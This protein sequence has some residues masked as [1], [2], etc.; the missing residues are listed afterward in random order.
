M[1]PYDPLVPVE[2]LIQRGLTHLPPWFSRW[3]GFRGGK[4]LPPS[5]SWMVC[6]YGFIG[7]FGGLSVILAIMEHTEYFTR[8]MVPPIVA[9]FV[10]Q[11]PTN[12]HRDIIDFDTGSLGDFMLRCHRRS[13]GAAARTRVWSLLQRTHWRYRRDHLPVQPR[14]RSV[15]T[16]PVALS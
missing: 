7:A 9:S 13:F 12:R 2:R 10:S 8:R 16:L 5:P 14:G 4:S 3:L 1:P 6:V 15:P 11:D